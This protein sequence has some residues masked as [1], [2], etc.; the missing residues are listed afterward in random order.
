M[1]TFFLFFR[2]AKFWMLLFGIHVSSMSQRYSAGTWVFMERWTCTARRRVGLFVV[3]VVILRIVLLPCNVV[4]WK[5]A[6]LPQTRSRLHLTKLQ[7]SKFAS[8]FRPKLES[9]ALGASSVESFACIFLADRFAT[10]YHRLNT[11]AIKKLLFLYQI[12]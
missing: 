1:L 11:K 12:N 4:L 8:K 3:A 6:T 5:V 2:R 7:S 9:L 10:F